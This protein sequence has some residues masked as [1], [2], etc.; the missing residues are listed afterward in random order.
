MH[1]AMLTQSIA[2]LKGICIF[3]GSVILRSGGLIISS[4]TC[5]AITDPCLHDRCQHT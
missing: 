1:L 3:S 2:T 5:H 4:A